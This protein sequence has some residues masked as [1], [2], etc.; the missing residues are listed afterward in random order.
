[1]KEDID[2]YDELPEVDLEHVEVL[3]KQFPKLNPVPT[4]DLADVMYHA[5]QQSVISWLEYAR[6]EQRRRQEF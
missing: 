1:M 4:D 3:R 5:G 2:L 6:E